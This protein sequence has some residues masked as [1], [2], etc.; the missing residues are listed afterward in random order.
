MPEPTFI[1][2]QPWAPPA[3]V[4][5]LLHEYRAWLCAEATRAAMPGDWH[6]G[7]QGA[8]DEVLA[9]MGRG[10]AQAGAFY[11]LKADGGPAAMG[12][13]RALGDGVAEIKRLY[14]RP[15][16]RRSGLG[17]RMLGQLLAELR[18]HAVC[19][20][21]APFMEPARRLYLDHG[22]ADCSPY[23]GTEVPTALHAQWHFMRREP[24]E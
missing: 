20:D 18:H 21:T 16:W 24:R 2:V 23:R 7:R 11:L 17:R 19:L 1:A 4:L 13:W 14:V 15:A 12:A 9:G 8:V 6:A 22:F 10:G 5:E 3:E